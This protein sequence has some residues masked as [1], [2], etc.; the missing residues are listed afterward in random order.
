MIPLIVWYHEH[1]DTVNTVTLSTQWH[2]QYSDT[3]NTVLPSIQWYC[4]YSHIVNMVTPSYSTL[5][6]LSLDRTTKQHIKKMVKGPG[7]NIYHLDC[8]S[9][10]QNKTIKYCFILNEFK[11]LNRRRFITAILHS[12]PFHQLSLHKLNKGGTRDSTS[13]F[14]FSPV[15][16]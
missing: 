1:G 6:A 10:K 14:M 16:T 13:H 4:Q 15:F 2:C 12:L 3:V 7:E 11:K 5:V 9:N 8:W